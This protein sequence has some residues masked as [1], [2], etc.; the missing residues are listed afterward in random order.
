MRWFHGLGRGRYLSFIGRNKTIFDKV[1]FAR[2]WLDT[3]ILWFSLFELG[4]G[5]W[6]FYEAYQ[7]ILLWMWLLNH[8]LRHTGTT[9]D[10]WLALVNFD[11]HCLSILVNLLDSSSR[12]YL[13]IEVRI[14]TFGTPS[15]HKQQ[16]KNFKSSTKS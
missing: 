8:R 11:S 6:I 3:F 10:S 5:V 12:W 16:I 4:F 15:L 13:R 7:L 1:L 14:T 2:F 9:P